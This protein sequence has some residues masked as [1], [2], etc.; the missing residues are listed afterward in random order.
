M[1]EDAIELPSVSAA[2]EFIHRDAP[3]SQSFDVTA[4]PLARTDACQPAPNASFSYATGLK[5]SVV[6]LTRE[7]LVH[8][9]CL[10]IAIFAASH[11][12]DE[13]SRFTQITV[14]QD[15]IRSLANNYRLQYGADPSPERLDALVERSIEQEM[16]YRQAI[17]LGLDTDDE[18]IRRRLVQKYEFLHQ[19]LVSP[20]EPTESQLLQFYEQHLPQYE[21]PPTVTFTHVYFSPD[22]RGE[23]RAREAAQALASDLN[24]RKLARSSEQGDRFPGSQDFANI[25][26]EALARVFGREGLSEAI[27]GVE[28][29]RWSDPLQSGYGWHTV[30]VS[31]NQPARQQSFDEVRD[32]VRRAY[33][34]AER[35]RQNEASLTKLRQSFQI[36]RE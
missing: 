26:P 16:L 27:L 20:A 36:V 35:N 23:E 14:T 6:H 28:P 9:L 25:S 4:D 34:E 1:S 31:A 29:N 33:L 2:P 32:Q 13:R 8:F 11:Y 7:P 24:L 12:V 22:A 10:G 21:R 19:D 17:K 18:I 3:L 15:Q 5:R 30:Y